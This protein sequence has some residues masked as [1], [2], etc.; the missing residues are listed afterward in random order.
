[1]IPSAFTYSPGGRLGYIITS[2]SVRQSSKIC[3]IFGLS[4]IQSDTQA[5]WDTGASGACISKSLAERLDLRSVEMC[6][7]SGISGIHSAQVYLIDIILPNNVIVKQVRATEFLDNGMF[8][9]II[10]MDIITLGDFAISNKDGN[11][12]L[13]FRIPSVEAIDFTQE[14]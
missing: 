1:M 10:G 13:S 14:I 3:K 12:M 4:H 6:D 5:L 11:T 9:A 7:V 8:N 2:V